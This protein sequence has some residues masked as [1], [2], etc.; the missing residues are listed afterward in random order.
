MTG[1]DL[2][3]RRPFRW[4]EPQQPGPHLSGAPQIPDQ[5]WPER[6]DLIGIDEEPDIPGVG[7]P[8][9]GAH[10]IGALFRIGGGEMLLELADRGGRPPKKVG[11]RGIVEKCG[12]CRWQPTRRHGEFRVA[13]RHGPSNGKATMDTPPALPRLSLS[14]LAALC[15]SGSKGYLN[16]PKAISTRIT[17]K[18]P[19]QMRAAPIRWVFPTWRV[20]LPLKPERAT[21][22]M[23]TTTIPR[24]TIQL[25][26]LSLV[27]RAFSGPPKLSLLTKSGDRAIWMP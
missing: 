3:Q 13:H 23:K 27:L 20:P 4:R 19:R 22:A 15:R 25:I 9:E 8:Q 18:M 1:A 17:R 21:R 24:M 14:D 11:P 10:P 26:A 2:T 7:F 5:A 12:R 16:T 6:T